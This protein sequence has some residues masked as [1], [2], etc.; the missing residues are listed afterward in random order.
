MQGEEIAL[1]VDDKAIQKVAKLLRERPKIL[2]VFDVGSDGKRRLI[3]H[4]PE[5]DLSTLFEAKLITPANAVFRPQY[6][7][8]RERAGV[9]VTRDYPRTEHEHSEEPN[10]PSDR[11]FP[12][13]DEAD[14][15]FDF[16]VRAYTGY[17]PPR[18]IL[19]MCSGS[20]ALALSLSQHW[21]SNGSKL[22]EVTGVDISE[23]A[24]Q[25]SEFN[26][27]LNRF[28]GHP[29]AERI[30]FKRGDLFEPL[31][32]DEK[33]DLIVAD[34]PYSLHPRHHV[35]SGFHGGGVFGTDVVEALLRHCRTWL[36][37]GGRLI[38]PCYSLGDLRAPTRIDSILR[39]TL[40]V[41]RGFADGLVEHMKGWKVWR[42]RDVK[43]MPNPMPVEYMVVRCSDPTYTFYNLFRRD[44]VG[45]MQEFVDNWIEKLKHEKDTYG[46]TYT[47]LWYVMINYKQTVRPARI[48]AR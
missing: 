25:R 3:Q 6:R 33:F 30:R 43:C 17:P 18:R 39:S 28:D 14:E 8:Q 34:P 15:I 42:F 40:D 45:E 29:F 11:V 5:N 19:N 38:C 31:S 37:P 46:N 36:A 48:K 21:S 20:G 16:A 22:M 44:P 13:R 1:D 12:W 4:L 10:H 24:V 7:L 47:N 2:D 32:A 9:L 26:R 27:R 41:E 23:R 35:K